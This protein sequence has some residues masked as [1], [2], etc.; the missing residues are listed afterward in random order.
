MVGA[1][2]FEPSTPTTPLWCATKLRYAPTVRTEPLVLYTLLIPAAAH[3]LPQ[4][5]LKRNRKFLFEEFE[6]LFQL[7]TDFVD[8]LLA[9]LVGLWLDIIIQLLTGA[10]NGKALFV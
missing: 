8:Q 7:D 3:S 5:S 9:A 10:T 4:S 2:G 1:K 6:Q